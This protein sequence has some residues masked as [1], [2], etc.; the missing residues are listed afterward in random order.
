MIEL[1]IFGSS[2]NFGLMIGSTI[3]GFL[4]DKIGRKNIL[5]LG[6]I[7]QVNHYITYRHL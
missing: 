3:C 2:F 6:T 7:L 1:V 4:A 5:I